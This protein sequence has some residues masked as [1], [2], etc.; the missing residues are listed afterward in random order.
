[1]ADEILVLNYNKGN[2]CMATF[3]IDGLSVNVLVDTGA[4]MT[5]IDAKLYRA[6]PDRVKYDLQPCPKAKIKSATG[7]EI[8]ILG[9]TEIPFSCAAGEFPMWTYVCENLSQHAVIGMNMMR[10]YAPWH[11]QVGKYK[12]KLIINGVDADS[13]WRRDVQAIETVRVPPNGQAHVR[14]RF[15]RGQTVEQLVADLPPNAL[16][17]GH[18]SDNTELKEHPGFAVLNVVWRLHCDVCSAVGVVTLLNPHPRSIV[19]EKGQTV[20]EMTPVVKTWTP[21]P[22]VCKETDENALVKQPLTKPQ[23]HIAQREQT[24]RERRAEQK[25]RCNARRE[26]ANR[27]RRL[28]VGADKCNG[29]PATEEEIKQIIDENKAEVMQ[30]NALT[31]YEKQDQH[32]S[33]HNA[34]A[35]PGSDEKRAWD[36]KGLQEYEKMIEKAVAN[37]PLQADKEFV[38]KELREL[39]YCFSKGKH[40]LGRVE[41]QTHTIRTVDGAQPPKEAPRRLRKDLQ[42]ECGR[43]LVEMSKYGIIAQ[44]Q[45]PYAAPIVM[46]R[47]KDGSARMCIDYRRLNAITVKDAWPLPRIDDTLDRL[48]QAKWFCTLDMASG[49]WQIALDEEDRKKT[50]FVTQHGQYVFNVLPFGLANAPATFSRMMDRV[51]TGLPPEI[52]MCYLDDVIVVGKDVK[53][54]MANLRRVMERFAAAGLKF[55]PKKCELFQKEVS[56]L[57]HIV[58]EKGIKMD[59]E[60][61]RVIREWPQPRNTTELSAYLGLTGYYRR[62]VEHFARITAPLNEKMQKGVEWSWTEACERAFVELKRVMMDDIVLAYPDWDKPFILDTDASNVALGAMLSQE[63]IVNGKK[64]ER[65]IAAYSKSLSKAARNYCVT[66]RELLAIVEA[67]KHFRPYL[68]YKFLLRTDHSSLRWL[69]SLRNADHQLARW[70]AALQE[71]NFD[72]QHRPGK[73]HGD[74]DALSRV[75]GERHIDKMNTAKRPCA[76]AG[77][78]YCDRVENKANVCMKPADGEFEDE[79]NDPTVYDRDELERL[80]K[81]QEQKFYAITVCADELYEDANMAKEQQND[82]QIAVV[83]KHVSEG[84]KP[85]VQHITQFSPETR[86]YYKD[87]ER[88]IIENGVLKRKF[89]WQE[90]GVEQIWHQTILPTKLRRGIL[91]LYHDQPTTGHKGWKA[92][93][94]RVGRRFH[95][96]GLRT[97]CQTYVKTCDKCQ[98]AQSRYGS[99]APLRTVKNYAPFSRIAMDI[100]KLTP[101]EYR[102]EKYKAILVVSDHFTKWAEAYPLQD[103][104][105]ERVAHLLWERLFS[106]VGWPEELH[107]DRGTEFESGLV[108]ELAALAATD[109][110]ATC[111]YHPQADGQVERLN[112]VIQEMLR[113]FC[114]KN[115]TSWPK[116]LDAVMCAYRSA[117]HTATGFTPNRMVFGNEIRL[118]QDLMTGFAPNEVPQEAAKYVAELRSHLDSAHHIA[119]QT[120]HAAFRSAKRQYDQKAKERAF[121]VGDAV[122]YYDPTLHLGEKAK[123]TLRWGGPY[124]VTQVLNANA[125]KIQLNSRTRPKYISI[126][127]L[128][129][130]KGLDKPTWFEDKQAKTVRSKQQQ[131][132]ERNE[133]T[134][135]AKQRDGETL[136]QTQRVDYRRLHEPSMND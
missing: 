32:W 4:T 79:Y 41:V 38:K 48:S 68:G 55:G 42:D 136:R 10:Q 92:T 84:V 121:Q 21:K 31:N 107:S 16:M 72:L 51:M 109:K 27:K 35:N 135:P 26:I 15:K 117:V 11:I 3:E 130:Y 127:R 131:S 60:K 50:G 74:A 33:S 17:A 132:Q 66:R 56:F 8:R 5:A 6:L 95:W 24:K 13:S 82:E 70:Q 106:K 22:R 52:A 98:A 73:L 75:A 89:L 61:L 49:Y 1:M 77:C 123:L 57:G 30:L 40:D 120:L 126:Q 94:R 97:F 37:L 93:W 100:M 122:W 87:F 36:E 23:W 78:N 47:K 9:K 129:L 58:S 119:R 105:T 133:V 113:S 76:A 19:V 85:P 90:D 54:T 7:H 53:S 128:K 67:T 114:D 64:V 118:P 65:P 83:Y 101:A 25:R 116:Y 34:P 71:F 88:L 134:K 102:G 43:M 45:S 18:V 63:T 20:A 80:K 111:A 29:P 28:M 81:E 104:T 112:R 96:F 59:P 99:R 115:P 14:A 12:N 91:R 2:K 103:E 124:I 69:Q 108:K 125:Y 39:Q 86:S 62:F 44:E 46:V 110:T